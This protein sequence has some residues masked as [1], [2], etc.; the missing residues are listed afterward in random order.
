[1]EILIHCISSTFMDIS[2]HYVS[3]SWGLWSIIYCMWRWPQMSHFVYHAYSWPLYSCIQDFYTYLQSYV[4]IDYCTILMDGWFFH[5]V[6]HHSTSGMD[7]IMYFRLH[8]TPPTSHIRRNLLQLILPHMVD[9]IFMAFPIPL[10][11]LWTPWTIFFTFDVSKIIPKNTHY[12][13][14]ANF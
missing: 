5:L 6:L 9:H 4:E 14:L 10:Q 7:F 1:M 2:I 8:V 11:T 3:S 12:W 13:I